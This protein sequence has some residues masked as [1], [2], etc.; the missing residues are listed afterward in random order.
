[1]SFC[2]LEFLKLCSWQCPFNRYLGVTIYVINFECCFLFEQHMFIQLDTDDLT[3]EN[4]ITKSFDK[5]LRLQLN[6]VWHQLVR[7]PTYTLILLKSKFVFW[8]EL[9]FVAC[10]P[11]VHVRH[12]WEEHARS[13]CLCIRTF[14]CSYVPLLLIPFLTKS[15]YNVCMKK[16]CP[17]SEYYPPSQATP[18]DETF[19]V[20]VLPSKSSHPTRRNFLY[21]SL[22]IAAVPLQE[23]AWS[24]L[25]GTQWPWVWGHSLW[26]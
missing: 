24:W 4:S 2:S 8:W 19:L 11:V 18:R 23:K 6:P 22:K 14:I 10:F 13:W 26:R 3:V 7:N 15:L 1:M 17:W 25:R 9:A 21:I 5:I 16:S 20:G 12:K